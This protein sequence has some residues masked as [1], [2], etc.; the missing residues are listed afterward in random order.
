MFENNFVDAQFLQAV[1][2][3]E[4]D[5]VRL[6]VV[7]CVNGRTS[8]CPHDWNL[9]TPIANARATFN[10]RNEWSGRDI[11]LKLENGH[12]TILRPHEP[13]QHPIQR[14]LNMIVDPDVKLECP[15]ERQLLHLESTLGGVPD[16][17]RPKS[18]T[19]LWDEVVQA[20]PARQAVPMSP[21]VPLSLSALTGSLPI[22]IVE[23][24]SNGGHD[25][26]VSSPSNGAA[27]S[28]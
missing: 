20:D 24:K 3:Q 26:D 12:F 7:N 28:L 18:V 2:P 15:G 17:T 10:S 23:D 13:T 5:D 8:F 22:P 11:I 1:W 16:S 19:Q 4:L 14:L 21:P 6:L 25:S 27:V 9:F